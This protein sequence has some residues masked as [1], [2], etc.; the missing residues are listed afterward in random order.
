MRK[1][2][3][4]YVVFGVKSEHDHDQQHHHHHHHLSEVN[5]EKRDKDEDGKESS[6]MQWDVNKLIE[7]YYYRSSSD[8]DGN[9]HNDKQKRLSFFFLLLSSS[10]GIIVRLFN[11]YRLV[12]YLLTNSS[13]RV[14]LSELIE[15][16]S[17]LSFI[18]PMI[19]LISDCN[20]FIPSVIRFLP[21][22]VRYTSVEEDDDA[23]D[24][25]EL[26]DDVPSM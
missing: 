9:D 24:V 6:L 22:F 13:N 7:S 10:P 23:V 21:R 25:V 11:E 26:V 12:E 5:E 15:D 8:G 14:I 2:G 16:T 3:V 17:S 20:I 4:C 19:S 1:V 18:S